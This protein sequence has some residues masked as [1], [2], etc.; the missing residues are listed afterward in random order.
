MGGARAMVVAV[1]LAAGVAPAMP[2]AG[3]DVPRRPVPASPR[4]DGGPGDSESPALVAGVVGA[5]L[6][7]ARR[8]LG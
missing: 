4:T 1:V 7:L 5:L 3:G 8:R 6:F 2:D